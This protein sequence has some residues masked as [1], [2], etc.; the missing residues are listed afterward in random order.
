VDRLPEHE[1]GR[2][3]KGGRQSSTSLASDSTSVPRA[4][5]VKV[6]D[7]LD[8]PKAT[9]RV[10]TVTVA[11]PYCQRTHT[12]GWPAGFDTPGVRLSHCVDSLARSYVITL[13]GAA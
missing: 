5:V 12:H 6:F 1:N 8:H 7:A 11:C 3:G 9:H 4:H 13:D 10:R 2:P